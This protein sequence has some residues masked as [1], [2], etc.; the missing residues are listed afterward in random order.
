MCIFLTIFSVYMMLKIRLDK[1]HGMF[2]KKLIP[3]IIIEVLLLPY[4]LDK[5]VFIYFLLCL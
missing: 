2:E 5:M 1:L 4:F 3:Y